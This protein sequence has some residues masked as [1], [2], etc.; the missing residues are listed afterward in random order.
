M[1]DAYGM[2]KYD[3]IMVFYI[4]IGAANDGI[5]IIKFV[6]RSCVIQCYEGYSHYSR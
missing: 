1:D 3:Y 5:F 4:W 6:P 2:L